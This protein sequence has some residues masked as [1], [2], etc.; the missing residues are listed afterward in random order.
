MF[1][2]QNQL[3]KIQCNPLP[4]KAGSLSP[5][6]S[7][8]PA[9]Q[10]MRVKRKLKMNVGDL[11]RPGVQIVDG[12]SLCVFRGQKRLACLSFACKTTVSKSKG[13]LTWVCAVSLSGLRTHSVM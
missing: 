3:F 4:E 8:P 10:K 9:R 12:W 1:Y 6:K 11:P 7:E 2:L 5:G 13:Q